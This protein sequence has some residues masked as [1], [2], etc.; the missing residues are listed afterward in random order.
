MELHEVLEKVR[1]G[2]MSIDEAVGEL[3]MLAFERV[4]EVAKLDTHRAARCGVPE[5]ILGEGKSPQEVE[6]LARAMLSSRGRALV[7]RVSEEQRKR[8]EHMVGFTWHARPRL[9]V[10]RSAPPLACGG[11]VGMVT[12]GT[13][14]VPVAE[15]ARIIAEEMGC[16]TRAAYDVGVAGIH[17]LFPDL[18]ELLTW[19]PDTLVVAA[20]REG[21]LPAVVAGLCDVP[22][23]GLPTSTGYGEGGGGR[24]ALYSML[25]SCS[26]LAVVN[27][28]N[29]VG[30][31]AF[32]ALVAVRAASARRQ[33]NARGGKG[34]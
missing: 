5:V 26:V 33:A 21:T 32:A 8:L 22:V 29:G 25:Q 11:R 15:E 31:G 7:S 18:G 1:S 10:L 13:S 9:A 30:A 24:A 2:A 4:G 16:E 14:D 12:A 19:K 6:D 27:I 17:R 28:D 20:G 23:V 3:R 34:G